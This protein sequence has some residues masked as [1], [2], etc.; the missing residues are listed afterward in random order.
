M[1]ID[2]RY[3]HTRHHLTVD[4]HLIE[5]PDEVSCR[6]SELSD[7][8]LNVEHIQRRKGKQLN[9]KLEH[10]KTCFSSSIHPECPIGSNSTPQHA[11]SSKVL[12]RGDKLQFNR[13]STT[14]SELTI[15][16]MPRAAGA[17]SAGK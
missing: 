1:R 16:D 3:V 14:T 6:R 8:L 2:L 12:A 10:K 17:V 7:I 11:S 5:I 4:V 9:V 13:T 15:A